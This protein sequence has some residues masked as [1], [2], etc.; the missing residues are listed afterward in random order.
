[1]VV[2]SDVVVGVNVDEVDDE[3]VVVVVITFAWSKK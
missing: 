1:V 2:E 3:V